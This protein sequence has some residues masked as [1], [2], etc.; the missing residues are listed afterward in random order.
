MTVTGISEKLSKKLKSLEQQKG[1]GWL[2]VNTHTLFF[3]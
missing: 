2:I 3:A 1:E